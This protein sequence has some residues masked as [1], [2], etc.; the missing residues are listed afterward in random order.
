M[1]I[2]WIGSPNYDTNRKPI[3]R[4]IIHWIVGNLAAADAVFQNDER[5]TSAHYGIEDDKVHQYV[6]EEHVAYHA[7]NYSIN[8]ESIGIEHSASPERP[9]SDATYR[10]SAQLIRELCDRYHIP[11]DLDHIEPHNKYRATQCP[12]T[13][14][15]N[16][17]IAMARDGSENVMVQVPSKTFEKLVTKSTN[18]DELL[19]E[20]ERVSKLLHDNKETNKQKTRTIEE[21]QNTIDLH[22]GTIDAQANTL[23]AQD[24]QLQEQGAQIET[25]EQANTQLKQEL[26][27]CES[28]ECPPNLR[29]PSWMQWL[30]RRFC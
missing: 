24:T 4:I 14:D 17:L 23:E 22:Q 29:C 8:Q 10:T 5:D 25:L 11:I 3:K 13:M 21:L 1:N 6:K 26:E 7:G 15:I 27:A 28:Q 20:Y 19:P 30:I 18:Y 12:G 16:R 9:A 2:K